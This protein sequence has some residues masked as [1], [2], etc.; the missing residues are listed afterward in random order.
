MREATAGETVAS[1][2]SKRLATAAGQSR[3]RIPGGLLPPLRFQAPERRI[4]LYLLARRQDSRGA[5][6]HTALDAASSTL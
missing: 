1:A 4:R 3:V 6:P 2:A 5:I